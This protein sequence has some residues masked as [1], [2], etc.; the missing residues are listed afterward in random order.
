M[1]ALKICATRNWFKT[2][3]YNENLFEQIFFEPENWN[4]IKTNS[5]YNLIIQFCHK[6]KIQKIFG[7]IFKVL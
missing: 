5:E 2:F 7:V 3:Y 6:H 4:V 1:R